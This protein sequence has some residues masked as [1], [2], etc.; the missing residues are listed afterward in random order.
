MN[1]LLR[2]TLSLSVSAIIAGLSIGSVYGQAAKVTGEAPS[3]DDIPSPEFSGGKQKSF[4]PKDWLEIEAKLNI[5]LAPEPKSKTLDRLTVKWYVAVKNPEKPRAML[6]L[7]KDVEHVNVPLGKISIVRFIFL[8]HRSDFLPVLIEAVRVRS[9]RL[10]TK[11]SLMAGPL[12]QKPPSSSLAG[13]AQPPT[14]FPAATRCLFSTSPKRPSAICGGI[15]M[16]K[17]VSSA[18]KAGITQ[19]VVLLRF[20]FRRIIIPAFPHYG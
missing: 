8:R 15:A 4:K 12:L 19:S 17:L 5:A 10:A 20:P 2:K 7:T 9:R 3:F 11:C 13:G 16:R 6:L 14:R 1:V 18:D